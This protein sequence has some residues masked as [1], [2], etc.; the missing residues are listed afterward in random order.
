VDED[1]VRDGYRDALAWML[2]CLDLDAEG[3]SAV[4]GSADPVMVYG[5]LA[6]LLID[7]LELRGIDVREWIAGRQAADRAALARA[8]G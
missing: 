1:R 3:A 8:G 5:A 6:Q 2:C 7:Q 4:R